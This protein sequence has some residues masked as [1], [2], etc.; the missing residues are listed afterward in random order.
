MLNKSTASGKIHHYDVF[1]IHGRIE[2]VEQDRI[3]AFIGGKVFL[4][5]KINTMVVL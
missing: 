4:E 5:Y 3:A 1:V 2:H